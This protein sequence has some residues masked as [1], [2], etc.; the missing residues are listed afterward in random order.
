MND[1]LPVRRGPG[2]LLIAITI[3]GTISV[4]FAMLFRSMALPPTSP[5]IGR[6]F[7]PITAA[8][9]INGA[10]PAADDF[11]GQ[12]IVVDAWAY[13]CGPCRIATEQVVGIHD[14]YKSRGVRFI[15][16][17]SEGAD[18]KSVALSRKFVSDLHVPWPNGY[19]AT[20]V[21]SELEV[22]SIPQL[23][24][25]DRQNRIVFHEVGF[26]PTSIHDLEVAL[27]K[28]LAAPAGK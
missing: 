15:G 1:E 24:V 27:D 23:W 20:K 14:K 4:G 11:N 25:I 2:G 12:V 16:L 17:T 10:A 5:Q 22:D 8:G 7:P 9:W 21:L 28:A 3:I 13:W 19:S 6:Q 26:S 18:S